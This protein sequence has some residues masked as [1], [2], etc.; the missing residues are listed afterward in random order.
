MKSLLFFLV[1][2]VAVTST[3][4]GLIMISNPDGRILNLSLDL[5][6]GTPFKNFMIPGILLTA[7]VGGTNL[8]AVFYNLQRHPNRYNLAM[9]GGT[10]ISGWII[11]QMILIQA[12]NWL[13]IVSLVIGIMII[14]LS[15]HLKGKWAV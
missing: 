13:H 8:L 10:M 2:F 9:A 6:E 4:S 14:L 12:V 15:Y 1:S 5:L 3:L 11:T 7:T